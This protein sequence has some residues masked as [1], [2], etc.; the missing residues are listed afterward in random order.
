MLPLLKDCTPAT[1]HGRSRFVAERGIERVA[2][3]PSPSAMLIKFDLAVG[4]GALVGPWTR[5]MQ[6]VPADAGLVSAAVA[7]GADETATCS[8]SAT[9]AT[10]PAPSGCSCSC[11]CAADGSG[12]FATGI[13][14]SRRS[15]AST[16]GVFSA[17]SMRY[18]PLVVLVDEGEQARDDEVHGAE[19]AGDGFPIW[20]RSVRRWVKCGEKVKVGPEF[21]ELPR[22]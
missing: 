15:A 16:G 8:S 11:P 19:R 4:E 5:P 7:A 12:S 2:A 6:R 22:V 10:H 21:S 14:S 18:S 1:A 20:T 3:T 13:R 17:A 9:S